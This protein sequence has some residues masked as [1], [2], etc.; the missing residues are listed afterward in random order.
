[1]ATGSVIRP[2]ETKSFEDALELHQKV[3][4]TDGYTALGRAM[5]EHNMQV[6]SKIYMN[7]TFEELGSFLGIRADQAE[8]IIARMIAE[9]RLNGVILD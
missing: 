4:F 1:M 8:T 5:I 2:S 6:L 3:V 9:E 7:I